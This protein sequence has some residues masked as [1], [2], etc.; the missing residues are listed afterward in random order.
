[1]LD[2]LRI[3]VGKYCFLGLFFVVL[4]DYLKRCELVDYGRKNLVIEKCKMKRVFLGF[5]DEWRREL[6]FC[7]FLG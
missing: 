2:K 3:R 4:C 5:L 7:F 6:C 1:M